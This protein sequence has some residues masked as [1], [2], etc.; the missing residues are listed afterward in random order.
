MAFTSHFIITIICVSIAQRQAAPPA[1]GRRP[2]LTADAGEPRNNCRLLA[3]SLPARLASNEAPITR[4]RAIS[5]CFALVWFGFAGR[6]NRCFAP[7]GA[8]LAKAH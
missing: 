8:P 3:A 1:A 6:R 4:E 5:V 2:P 7:N